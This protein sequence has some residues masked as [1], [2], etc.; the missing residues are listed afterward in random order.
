[1]HWTVS[2]TGRIVAPPVENARRAPPYPRWELQDEEEDEGEAAPQGA[3]I[4]SIRPRQRAAY[5]PLA[6]R[7]RSRAFPDPGPF[8]PDV[9][10][11]L[12]IR[13]AVIPSG[14]QLAHH[15]EHDRPARDRH[16]SAAAWLDHQ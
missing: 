5:P 14:G 15:R 9:H 1:M 11:H 12:R 2:I 10:R 4:A 3:F 8:G 16:K 7:R 6:G 13:R